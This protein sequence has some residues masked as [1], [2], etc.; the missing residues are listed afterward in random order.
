MTALLPPSS[1]R[2][3]P[4]RAATRSPTLRPTSVE[5]VKET[6]ATR[7]SSTKRVASSVPKSM[8]IWNTAGSLLSAIT[9]L[10]SV[11][12]ASAVSGVL[13]EGFHT[14]ALPQ[15]APRKAFQD[16]TATGKL[17]AEMIPITPSG[18]HCSYMRCCGRSECMVRP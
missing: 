14:E 6:S 10:H 16:H 2:L 13:G 9:L 8:K 12:T 5:P 7:R 11:C 17:N 4:R 1:S 18:C 3:F 15:I